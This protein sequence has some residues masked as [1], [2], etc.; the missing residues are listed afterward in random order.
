MC[1]RHGGYSTTLIGTQTIA[2]VSYLA[3]LQRAMHVYIHSSDVATRITLLDS[4]YACM[5]YYIHIMT[6]NQKTNTERACTHTHTYT[7][8]A[9][10]TIHSSSFVQSKH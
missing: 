2:L 9:K 7:Y 10:I 8:V 6:H 5:L 1:Y 4:L 3:I